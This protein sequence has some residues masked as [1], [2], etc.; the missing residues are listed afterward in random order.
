MSEGLE[1][2]SEYSAYAEPYL[3]LDFVTEPEFASFWLDEVDL[4][5]MRSGWATSLVNFA[6]IRRK[7]EHGNSADSR[8]AGHLLD[9]GLMITEDKGFHAALEFV[10]PLI[11]DAAQPRL[12]DRGDPDLVSQLAAAVA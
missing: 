5:R 1:T 10:T 9:A 7:I 2:L 3:R 8:H 4:S 6:Q 12:L 11:A